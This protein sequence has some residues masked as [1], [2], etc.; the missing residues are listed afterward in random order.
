MSETSDRLPCAT[1]GCSGT[2]LPSTAARTGGYCMPCVQRKA[3]EEEKAYIKANRVDVDPYQGV[4]DPIE[5]IQ[6][7]HRPIAFDPLKRMLPYPRPIDSVY[8]TLTADDFSRLVD[9]GTGLVKSGESDLAEHICQSLATFTEFDLDRFLESFVAARLYYPSV[10]FRYASPRICE[11]L[12]ER[13]KSDHENRNHILCALAWIGDSSVASLFASWR[14]EPPSWRRSLHVP[15]E[16]YAHQAGWEIDEAG[17]R[18]NLYSTPCRVIQKAPIQSASKIAIATK[19]TASCRWC[20]NS[21]VNLFDFSECENE[22]VEGPHRI[23]TCS[24]CSCY[25]PV[26]AELDSSGF[27]AWCPENPRPSYLPESFEDWPEL[28][29]VTLSIVPTPRLPF[30][31]TDWCAEPVV[32]QVGGLPTWIQDAEYPSCVRCQRTMRFVA[33]L[34]HDEIES[35]SEG[36][37][38]AFYCASCR[39]TAT[40]YQQS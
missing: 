2:I 38:Y 29:N 40:S 11:I 39:L 10:M 27:G 35:P 5:I 23:A 25:G 18:R 16:N 36:I 8:S 34:A 15:P 33:Q 19:S 7:Y 24:R 13:L 17:K 3:R 4:E 9:V 1:A 21:L 22:M 6:I 32:S 12:V 28:P 30:H 31:A 20:N 14:K 26:F 37:Y